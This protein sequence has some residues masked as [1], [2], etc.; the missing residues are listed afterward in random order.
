MDDRQV[1]Q[2]VPHDAMFMGQTYFPAI[3]NVEVALR[4]VKIIPAKG[5]A[6]CAFRSLVQAIHQ[7][8]ST[9]SKDDMEVKMMKTRVLAQCYCWATGGCARAFKEGCANLTGRR[10]LSEAHIA[11]LRLMGIRVQDLG[12]EGENAT[13][14][15]FRAL[16]RDMCESNTRIPVPMLSFACHVLGR[17]IVL[18]QPDESGERIKVYATSALMESFKGLLISDINSE[19]LHI[20]CSGGKDK[21]S[22][23]YLVPDAIGAKIHHFE[24]VVLETHVAKSF[25]EQLKAVKLGDRSSRP[26]LIEGSTACTGVH[27]REG[28]S[29]VDPA[30]SPSTE[31]NVPPVSE[32][33]GVF[34]QVPLRSG[35]RR[36]QAC[37]VR[38]HQPGRATCARHAKR[39]EPPPERHDPPARSPDNERENASPPS[40]GVGLD[41]D[42]ETEMPEILM[43]TDD[44]EE[45]AALASESKIKIRAKEIPEEAY[46]NAYLDVQDLHEFHPEKV[47]PFAWVQK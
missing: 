40:T 26:P 33:P 22:K 39:R 47:K 13:I 25:S 5:D 24:T 32:T 6:K 2:G 44:D 28:T 4:D 21:A 34:C 45:P 18:W 41:S 14:A 29:G 35:Q 12:S 11:S 3:H 42:S 36:G 16:V 17:N 30:Y 8:S 20:L 23:R 37:G 46:R 31:S 9:D 7:G 43:D 1:P 15:S 10:D 19:F 27:C 38:I